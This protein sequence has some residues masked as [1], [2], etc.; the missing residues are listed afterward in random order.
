M[1][2]NVTGGIF[3]VFVQ[4][5]ISCLRFNFRSVGKSTGK[6][7]N[8]TGEQSDVIACINYLSNFRKK[9]RILLCGYSYGAAIGCSTVNYSEAVIGFCAISFPWDF[10]GEK[11]K[12][13]T[14]TSKVKLFMQGNRDNVALYSRFEEH[15]SYYS[16]PKEKVVID[17]ADHFYWGYEKQVAQE[18][19]RF[20]LSLNEC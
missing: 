1:H 10:M 2:N 8:G 11:Y 14:Q 17:G 9:N 13:M 19:L 18:I 6:H 5:D 12:E 3:N 20:Y 4:N 16:D 15:F 7:S